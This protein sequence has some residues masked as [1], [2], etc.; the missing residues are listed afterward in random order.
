MKNPPAAETCGLGFSG[1]GLL[2]KRTPACL[3]DT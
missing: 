2:C 1:R 3:S